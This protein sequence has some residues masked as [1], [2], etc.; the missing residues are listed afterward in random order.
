MR[1]PRPP[2][3]QVTPG[4]EFHLARSG[5]FRLLT[6]IV[7]VTMHLPSAHGE[8]ARGYAHWFLLGKCQQRGSPPG[9][10]SSPKARLRLRL[11]PIG[12]LRRRR[13]RRGTRRSTRTRHLPA[14]ILRVVRPVAATRGTSSGGDA[15]TA[16]CRG[17]SE[18]PPACSATDAGCVN[19]DGSHLCLGRYVHETWHECE[20]GYVWPLDADVEI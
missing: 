8:S 11:A 15:R 7:W 16:V 20:C 13:R 12:H 9:G 1:A 18:P 3:R 5:F 6:D 2:T 10:R 14:H 19:N 17:S 4:R